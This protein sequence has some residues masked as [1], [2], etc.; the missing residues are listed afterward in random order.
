MNISIR[1]LFDIRTKT[2][3]GAMLVALALLAS[4]SA[5]QT[6]TSALAG[7]TMAIS[8]RGSRPV[9]PGP[10]AQFTGTVRVEPLFAATDASRASAAS[11]TFDPGARSAWHSHPLGQR[12]V[13]TAGTGRVQQWGGRV[14]EIRAG[15]V[16]WTPPGVKHWHGAA[17]ETAMH[18][19]AIHEALDGN[20]VDWMEHV[21]DEQYLAAPRVP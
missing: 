12:L 14:K 3:I 20:V 11:V 10:A 4:P 15:D 8:R 21:S 13:V 18:H 1:R 7:D 2:L 5:A 16:V 9:Q 17:P 19:I 6:R